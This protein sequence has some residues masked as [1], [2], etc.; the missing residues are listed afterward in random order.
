MGRSHAHPTNTA[1]GTTKS[2]ICVEEPIA[3]PIDK[4]SLS[5]RATGVPPTMFTLPL[6]KESTEEAPL[7]HASQAATIEDIEADSHTS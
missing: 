5:S 6:P 2:A 4:P 1:K 3:M 7:Q